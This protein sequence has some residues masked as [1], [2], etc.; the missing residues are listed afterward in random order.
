MSHKIVGKNVVGNDIED[1]KIIYKNI[2]HN[3][4]IRNKIVYKKTEEDAGGGER[5][6]RRGI[7]I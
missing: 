1:K 7:H 5:G 6:G 2:G 3:K 4:I